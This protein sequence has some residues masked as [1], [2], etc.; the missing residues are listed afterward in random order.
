[1]LPGA[2]PIVWQSA[3]CLSDRGKLHLTLGTNRRV[4][5]YGKLFAGTFDQPLQLLWVYPIERTGDNI[6]GKNLIFLYAVIGAASTNPCF[7]YL[8]P[9]GVLPE[10]CLP[11]VSLLLGTTPA[12]AVRCQSEGKRIRSTPTSGTIRIAKRRFTPGIVSSR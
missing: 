10:R 8:L 3:L 12:Q 5:S 4:G 6:T 7:K 9:L 2:L 11:L 1:V